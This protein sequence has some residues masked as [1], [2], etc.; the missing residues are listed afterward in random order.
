[1]Y[2]LVGALRYIN[3]SWK[4]DEDILTKTIET[5]IDETRFNLITLTTDGKYYLMDNDFLNTL[6]KRTQTLGNYLNNNAETLPELTEPVSVG[7]I[8][9]SDIEGI[10]RIGADY[11][12]PKAVP[13]VIS[14]HGITSADSSIVVGLHNK[15]IGLGDFNI[16]TLD[17]DIP[18]KKVRLSNSDFSSNGFKLRKKFDLNRT[19]LIFGDSF[20]KANRVFKDN[21]DGYSLADGYRVWLINM[22]IDNLQKI[23]P[24]SIGLNQAN[25]YKEQLASREIL[26]NLFTHSN[27]FFVEF[28]YDYPIGD[29]YI[30]I[31][32]EYIDDYYDGTVMC[33]SKPTTNKII[34]RHNL[35]Y[36]VKDIVGKE[37]MQLYND[38]HT[39]RLAAEDMVTSII[40]PTLLLLD[41][42]Q[43]TRK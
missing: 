30:E 19:L 1:M 3:G 35:G 2:Q 31:I 37:N 38:N 23:P 6:V 11:I 32:N 25:I 4:E 41:Y 21:G 36:S 18:M 15:L 10:E 26:I 12:L 29:E 27:V 7:N 8:G 33:N 22:Y 28:D 16:G 43:V 42:P 14:S 34:H 20:I 17:T 9:Y 40:K 13:F 24:I 5:I 39:I